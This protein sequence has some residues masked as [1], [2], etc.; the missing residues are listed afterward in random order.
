MNN[1]FTLKKAI[2]LSGKVS[3]GNTKMPSSTFAISSKHCNVGS[4]LVKIENSTCSKCYALKLQK[5]RP[6]VDQGW[7]NNLLKA[8]KLIETNPE[9]WAKM[10]SFQIKRICKKLNVKFH[11]WFDSGDLQSVEMLRAIVLSAQQT[12]DIKHWLPTREA[13]V[14]KDYKAK[15]GEIPSNLCIRVSATMIGDKPIKG[16]NNTST[17]H[18]KGSEVFGKE[19]LAYRTNIDSRVLTELQYSEFKKLD[20]PNKA[21]SKIDLGHCGDCRA[22]WSKEVNN[23]SYPLH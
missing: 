13:K 2:E 14:V 12:P 1:E 20:K 23:I 3:K 17:V 6:S 8:V 10:V 16:Y 21:K 19:C 9:L 22:C 7:T 11:R 4:K 18:R 5:L 15:Y